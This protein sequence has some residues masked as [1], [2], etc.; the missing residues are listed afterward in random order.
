MEKKFFDWADDPDLNGKSKVIEMPLVGDKKVDQEFKDLEDGY[1]YSKS[2]L[3]QK[4][5]NINL[6][7]NIVYYDPNDLKIDDKGRTYFFNNEG[8]R[9]YLTSD[10][11]IYYIRL[12]VN[13]EEEYTVFKGGTIL[14]FKDPEHTVG[15]TDQGDVYRYDADTDTYIYD[16]QLLI[17]S[18]K[19][20]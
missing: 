10:K 7:S 13:G 6:N 19:H 18:E 16:P 14:V 3:L 17:F 2:G 20:R 12:S 15:M 9:I 8:N 1:E 11:R 5:I 4:E